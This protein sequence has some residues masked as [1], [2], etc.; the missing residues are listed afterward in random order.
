MKFKSLLITAAIAICA[1]VAPPVMAAPT[2][3]WIDTS[4]MTPVYESESVT[5]TN[6][7]AVLTNDCAGD[8]IIEFSVEMTG[9]YQIHEGGPET[10]RKGTR[11]WRSAYRRRD[12]GK[13]PHHR[14]RLQ[15]PQH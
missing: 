9:R 2:G 8:S 13:R 1:A 12:R 14:A 11:H 5:T 15:P 10:G 6:Y 3:D 7:G 4:S